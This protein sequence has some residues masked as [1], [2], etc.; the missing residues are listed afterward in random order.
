[1]LVETLDVNKVKLSA[2]PPS[3]YWG[4]IAEWNLQLR[5]RNL[6]PSDLIEPKVWWEILNMC[7]R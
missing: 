6:K 5:K 1:M 3:D 4:S 7:E 2:V